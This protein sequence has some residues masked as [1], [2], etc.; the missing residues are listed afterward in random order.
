MPRRSH[1][2]EIE[3]LDPERDHYRIVY[4]S[5]LHEF[6][7]DTTRALELALFRTFA[8]PSVSAV[9]AQSGEFVRRPQRRYDDTDLLLSELVEHHYDSPRGRAALRRINQLHGRFDIANEDFLYVLSTFVFEPPRWVDRFGWRPMGEAERQA[10]YCFWREIGRRM[11]IRD[12]PDS[13]PAFEQYNLAYEAAHFRY[14]PANQAIGEAVR[15][16]LLGWVLPRPL[17]KLGQPAVHA[18]LDPPLRAAFGF[19]DPPAWVEAT[20][21][22]G[23]RA[24]GRL[25]RWLPERLRPHRRTLN[26]RPSYPSGYR[27]DGL[28]PP[29]GGAMEGS[30]R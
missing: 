6:P 25:V 16:M 11:A 13:R 4:L 2:D 21:T 30:G 27:L 23:L 14:S 18:L 9:L 24:R 12:I 19:P 22:T 3:R 8:V 7:W 29:D 20:V 5:A 17:A 28:G 26:P 15:D 10:S 1:L